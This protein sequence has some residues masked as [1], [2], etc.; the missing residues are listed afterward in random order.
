MEFAWAEG[1]LTQSG[2]I[3]LGPAERHPGGDR[4]ENAGF[5]A[6]LAVSADGQRLY[7]TQLYGQMVR[8]IDLQER[9]VVATA[10]L[11]AEPYTCV[12]SR[13]GKT[14]FVSLWGGG[15]VLLFDSATLEA[16]G[17]I[18][19]GEHPNAMELSRD[20]SRLFV[21]CASTNAVWVVDVATHEPP[22]NKSRWRSMHRHRW[23]RRR[24]ACRFRPTAGSC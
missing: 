21:A 9:R 5:V 24:T 19:V 10:Q 16:R 23:D 1:K 2:T 8:A 17:E 11:P 13:D 3:G 20:G 15:K 7:A 4:I 12:L 6:G 18:Q 14:L 22:T